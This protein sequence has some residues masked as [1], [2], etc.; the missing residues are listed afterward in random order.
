MLRHIVAYE[1]F[2]RD[3][4]IILGAIYHERSRR[5]EW[6]NL[7]I[8]LNVIY[9]LEPYANNRLK[10]LSKTPKL[11][12]VDTGLAAYLINSE[13]PQAL[14]N[15]KDSGHF[16]E[17]HVIM[18]LIKNL[19][20]ELGRYRVSY[21][22]DSNQKEIDL[23]MEAGGTLH[24]LEIKKSANPKLSEINKFDVFKQADAPLGN[25]GIICMTPEFTMI[26]EKNAF[27]PVNLI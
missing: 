2:S 1:I 5:N 24:P 10:R 12:F 4:T 19:Q 21:Y 18:D 14:M 26:D 13:S 8:G 27:I 7:L 16:L 6:I 17:N 22:R 3:T 15:S 20:N 23:V 9:L 11:Y 25:G